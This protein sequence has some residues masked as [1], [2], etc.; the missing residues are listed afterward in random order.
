MTRGAAFSLD[1]RHEIMKLRSS[2]EV[3]IYAIV[4][5]E[6]G[7]INRS[8]VIIK[9]YEKHDYSQI[10]DDSDSDESNTGGSSINT[11]SPRRHL[12]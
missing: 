12:C 1:L 6:N 10:N 9:V 5:H 3:I 2:K 4:G 7:M 11:I 8:R